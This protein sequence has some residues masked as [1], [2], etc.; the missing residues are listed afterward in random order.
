LKVDQLLDR[1]P[2]ALD[3]R[4]ATTAEMPKKAYSMIPMQA[5]ATSSSS[6]THDRSA[7]S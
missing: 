7:R 5:T 4:T 3:G 6:S 2:A 1:H